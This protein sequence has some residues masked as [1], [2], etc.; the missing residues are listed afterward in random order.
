MFKLILSRAMEEY[1][2]NLKVMISFG[3]LFLF[4]FLFVFFEQFSLSA[5]TVFLSFN[6]SVL[7]IIGLL[8]GLIFLYVFSFFIALTVYSVKRDVQHMSFDT[9]W[10]FLMKQASLKIF[11]FYFAFAIFT[12]VIS[13]IGLFFGVAQITMIICFIVSMILMY[14][15]QSIVLDEARVKESVV[16]SIEFWFSNVFTSL[17]ITFIGAVL[18]LV[19]IVL[20]FALE[21]FALPGV[22]LSFLIMMIIIVPF[23]EQMKSY[24]FVM[25]YNLIKQTEVMH[26]LAKPVKQIKINAV[27]L[28][29]KAKGGKI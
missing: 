15:P 10:N 22:V 20:E 11:L 7:T 27:R 14:V 8:L 2:A 1:R 9:Y 16:K 18:I 24:A 6:P 29:E 13:S 28:R 25:K 12:Y 21:F 23:V 19:I 4:L 26:S 5:G 3:V 17:A